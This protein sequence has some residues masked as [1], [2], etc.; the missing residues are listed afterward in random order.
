MDGW[1][2]LFHRCSFH[3]WMAT[4]INVCMD[5]WMGNVAIS[6]HGWMGGNMDNVC[7]MYVWMDYG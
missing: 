1:I 7:C 6:F 3:G 5:E 2:L 4:V